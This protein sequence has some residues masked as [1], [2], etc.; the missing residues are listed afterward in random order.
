MKRNDEISQRLAAIV[1]SSDDAIISKTLDG[2]ITSWNNAA[3]RIFGY[4]ADYLPSA[5]P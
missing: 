5:R 3:T 2:T 1:E 4:T